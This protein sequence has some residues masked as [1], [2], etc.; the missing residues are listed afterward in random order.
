MDF[1][2]E[3]ILCIKKSEF[4]KEMLQ[5]GFTKNY[6]DTIITVNSNDFDIP[7]AKSK[8]K[9]NNVKLDELDKMYNIVVELLESNDCQYF[10]FI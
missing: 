4:R 5:L 10:K 3:K 8:F 2:T 7:L 9:N 1:K 6:I